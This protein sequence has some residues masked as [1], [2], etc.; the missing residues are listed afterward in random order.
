MEI[1]YNYLDKKIYELKGEWISKP[2][3]YEEE[4][5]M[6]LDFNYKSGRYCD[7]EYNGTYIELKKGNSS[8]W[9]NEIRYAEILMYKWLKE[10]VTM[11]M[12]PSE[13]KA[14]IY[15]IYLI[16]TKDIIK[17]LCITPEWAIE[18][19][20]RN[21]EI[22]RSLQYQHNLTKKDLRDMAKYVVNYNHNSYTYY[23]LNWK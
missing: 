15:Y 3:Y 2:R 6:N 22:Q 5:C 16:D 12:I 8:A 4:A 14:K 1:L 23:R 17:A 7:C 20:K 10:T 19:I 11:F 21:K 18:V 9:F 13:N